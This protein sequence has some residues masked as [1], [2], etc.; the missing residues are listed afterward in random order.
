MSRAYRL[1]EARAYAKHA[2][3]NGGV[4]TTPTQVEWAVHGKCSNPREVR[5]EARKDPREDFYD[6][7]PIHTQISVRCR[8]CPNCLRF[9]AWQ[10]RE[11]AK[12]EIALAER[13][14]FGTITL[15]ETEQLK[16]LYRAQLGAKRRGVVW[17]HPVERAYGESL[18]DYE[19]RCSLWRFARIVRAIAPEITKWL[20]R[21]RK[22]SGA[23]LRFLLVAEAHKSGRPHFHILIN[24]AVG[25]SPIRKRTLDGQWKLGFTQFR[26]VAE[27]DKAAAYV[28]KYL[29]KSVLA[30]VRA[31][32]RYG[33]PSESVA[34]PEGRSACQENAP[35]KG[36]VSP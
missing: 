32:I 31:S 3:S 10:W 22:E 17:D 14:W 27:G 19:R 33:T 34:R 9:R 26:L 6:E 18:V 23:K 7:R 21:V 28:T 12:R 29:T 24:E 16:A 15:S 8:Q 25:S 1:R 11:R 4:L 30:R 20:K 13:T 36:G 5:L 35:T 2:L